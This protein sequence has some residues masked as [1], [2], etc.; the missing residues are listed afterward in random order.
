MNKISEKEFARLCAEI[1]RDRASIYK[2]NPIGTFEESLLWMLLGCL[3]SYLSL[4]EIETP[5]FTGKPN[6]E[7]YEKAIL[8]VL[9]NRKTENFEAAI[10]M[11][12]LLENTEKL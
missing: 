3:N 6:A 12:K 5:C 9:E 10:Y 1:Y 7:T 11:K 2:H 8:F 4:T